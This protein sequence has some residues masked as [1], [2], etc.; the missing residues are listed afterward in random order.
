MTKVQNKK[1]MLGLFCNSFFEIKYIK[2]KIAIRP[3]LHPRFS[4]LCRASNVQALGY[5]FRGK[6]KQIK[7]MDEEA[8]TVGLVK[9]FSLAR[10]AGH[11]RRGFDFGAGTSQGRSMIRKNYQPAQPNVHPFIGKGDHFVQLERYKNFILLKKDVWMNLRLV[12]D[13]ECL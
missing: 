2:W 4:G 5:L 13:S 7:E 3:L 10:K 8:K 9:P 11:M 1:H 12:V 6:S